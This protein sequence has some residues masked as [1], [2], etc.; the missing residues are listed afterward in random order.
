MRELIVAD[1]QKRGLLQKEQ[2]KKA[3]M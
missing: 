1:L 3:S 2:P